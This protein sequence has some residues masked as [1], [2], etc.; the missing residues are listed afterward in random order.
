[1]L[2]GIN[3]EPERWQDLVDLARKIESSLP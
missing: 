1:L 3:A 2:T